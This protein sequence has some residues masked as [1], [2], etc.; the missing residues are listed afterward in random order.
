[1]DFEGL[2]VEHTRFFR[3]DMTKLNV[4]VQRTWWEKLQF[5]REVGY[6]YKRR[7]GYDQFVRLLSRIPNTLLFIYTKEKQE[8]ADR[9]IE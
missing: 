3:K 4:C 7:P 6:F 1:M 8:I 5:W 9:L 2:L